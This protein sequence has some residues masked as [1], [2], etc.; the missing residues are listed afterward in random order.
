MIE[1]PLP[2]DAPAQAWVRAAGKGVAWLEA[3]LNDG[4]RLPASLHDL[5]SYYKWPLALATLGR[6]RQGEAMLTT[7]S[8]CFL[9]PDGD[10]RTSADKSSDPLYG[11]ISDTYTNTWPIAAARLLGRPDM[12]RHGLDG[13]RG[14]F[15]EATG[16]YLTGIPGQYEDNRQ[17]IVT[18]AGCGNAFLAWDA[19]DEAAGAGDCLMRILE[20][21]G[22]AD[23]PFHLYID[24][25]GETLEGELGIPETLARIDPAKPGQVYVYWGMASVFLARL[26]TVSHES[27]FLEGARAYFARH[28]A[29][30]DMVFDGIGCCKTGWA[31]A[32]LYRL[33][34]D[35]VYRDVVHKVAAEL[36]K[37]QCED[38]SWSRS[39]LS[40]QLNCDCTAEIVYHLSQYTL[41]LASARG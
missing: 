1:N 9:T 41:E 35:A 6:M 7:I 30:G 23:A 17:D 40:P 16:G 34:G 28:D 38:G 24:G 25:R 20:Q 19:M 36:L 5:A 4:S 22:P 21:Q 29:C 15:V 18:V 11:Q 3:A 27:R 39:Q 13:L 2:F 32:T 26:Y 14:R 12:G 10:F 8:D 31:A 37:V 33:T